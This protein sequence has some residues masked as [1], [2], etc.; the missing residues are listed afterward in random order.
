V[1]LVGSRGAR[2]AGSLDATDL[3]ATDTAYQSADHVTGRVTRRRDHA[4]RQWVRREGEMA[5]S[6]D[7]IAAIW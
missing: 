4:Q 2:E 7:R 6:A 3:D 1:K 5:Q